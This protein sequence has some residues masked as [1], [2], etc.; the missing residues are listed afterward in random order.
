MTPQPSNPDEQDPKPANNVV[1]WLGGPR[2]ILDDRRQPREVTRNTG[3]DEDDE[4]DEVLAMQQEASSASE[5][6]PAMPSPLAW[7][8]GITIVVVIPLVALGFFAMIAWRWSGSIANW[9]GLRGLSGRVGISVVMVIGVYFSYLIAEK[10]KAHRSRRRAAVGERSKQD[11]HAIRWAVGINGVCYCCAYH[12]APLP[13]EEDRCVVCPEC[14]AAWRVDDWAN[15]GGRYEFPNRASEKPMRSGMLSYSDRITDARDVP[16]PVLG[17]FT[18]RARAREVTRRAGRRIRDA[19]GRKIAILAVV[20][21]AAWPLAYAFGQN[22]MIGLLVSAFLVPL[23][24]LLALSARSIILSARVQRVGD[25]L[26]EAGLCPCC[27][28]P[29]RP[30]P[31]PIDACHLCE[32]C[33]SAWNPADPTSH[34]RA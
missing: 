25:E 6:S 2:L 26:I 1:A 27:E 11:E 13:R 17:H 30:E 28:S 31:S 24:V 15:D 19:L 29:L 12:I 7:I 8:W 4:R 20:L 21:L 33:G 18:G 34:P 9:L 22:R 16:V 5:P 3:F 23:V 14:G 10:H 32:T